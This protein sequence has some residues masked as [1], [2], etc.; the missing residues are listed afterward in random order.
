MEPP[1]AGAPV[2]EHIERRETLV[3]MYTV[4]VYTVLTGG[5]TV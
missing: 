1:P 3:L 2:S 4:P 5:G